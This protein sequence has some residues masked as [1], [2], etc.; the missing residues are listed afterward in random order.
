VTC[1]S[2]D[3]DQSVTTRRQ[4]TDKS[5]ES[6]VLNTAFCCSLDT[7]QSQS[8]GVDNQSSAD[9]SRSDTVSYVSQEDITTLSST[10]SSLSSLSTLSSCLEHCVSI[11]EC[12]VTVSDGSYC[13]LIATQFVPDFESTHLSHESGHTSENGLRCASTQCSYL[14]DTG[15]VLNDWK[16]E[17]CSANM[18]DSDS[19]SYDSA[20]LRQVQQLSDVLL[21]TKLIEFGESPGP[22]VSSTRTIQE[23]KLCSYMAG[24]NVKKDTVSGTV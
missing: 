20:V 5:S 4:T 21:R 17:S 7:T 3:Q 18:T 16:N 12:Y 14:N 22:I 11:E 8:T 6:S 15:L 10:L 2:S 9:A 1:L 19:V 13:S 23:L 24:D